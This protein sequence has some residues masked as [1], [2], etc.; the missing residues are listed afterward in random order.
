MPKLTKKAIRSRR[1]DPKYR[2]ASLFKMMLLEGTKKILKKPLPSNY[3][4]IMLAFL[5]LPSFFSISLI[6]SL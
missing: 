3:L 6:F 2:K 4:S 1:T 5:S